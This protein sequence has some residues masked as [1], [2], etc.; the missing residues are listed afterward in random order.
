MKIGRWA[1]QLWYLLNR[2]RFER[3]LEREM[4]AHRASMAEPYRFG[5]TLQLREAASDAWGWRWLD[6]LSLDL[7]YGARQLVR[8]PGFAAT[9]ILTLTLGIG[10]TTAIFS[11]LNSVLLRPLPVSDPDRLAILGNAVV[12]EMSSSYPV[13]LEIRDRRE[14]FDGTAALAAER[15][16][17]ASGGEA[18]FVQGLFVSGEFFSVL[19][20]RSALGRTLGP[21]DD[22]RG[23][24]QDGPVAVISHD[25]WQRRF[26]GSAGVLGQVLHLDSVAFT[27]V[28]IT[29][30][31]F[32]GIDVGQ[33]FDVAVLAATGSRSWFAFVA[34]R[35]LRV[36]PRSCAGCSS[37]FGRHSPPPAF[38]RTSG[39]SCSPLRGP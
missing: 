6:E 11:V 32:F 14:L 5:N 15:F 3:E 35:R 24:G 38:R 37:R 13:W 34:T 31:G 33:R 19:G 21:A 39:G 1:R 18:Q 10:A 30:P 7:R 29:P 12:K 28:G 17:L 2:R 36:G 9:A 20:V 23:G 22:R 25:F 16:N 4:A 8:A 27:I 26:G